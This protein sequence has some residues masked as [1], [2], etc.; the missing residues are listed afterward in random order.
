MN[1]RQR[2]FVTAV[3]A[4]IVVSLSA[5]G[6]DGKNNTVAAGSAKSSSTATEKKTEKK[7][8]ET[9]AAGWGDLNLRFVFDGTA[10]AP[11]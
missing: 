5:C 6:D 11:V 4:P 3:L 7:T 8:E 1:I 10:P 2:L 9:I